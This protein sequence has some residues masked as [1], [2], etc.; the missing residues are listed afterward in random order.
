MAES[1]IESLIQV[2]FVYALTTSILIIRTVS[3][4]VTKKNSGIKNKEINFSDYF[5]FQLSIFLFVSCGSKRN[6]ND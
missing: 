4:K 5:T 2:D 3:K 6:T 1:L